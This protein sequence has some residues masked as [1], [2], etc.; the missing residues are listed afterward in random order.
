MRIVECLH[1]GVKNRVASASFSKI[2]VCGKCGAP[3]PE[4]A[5]A[6]GL[7]TL[8]KYRYWVIL[9]AIVGGAFLT[10]ELQESRRSPAARATPATTSAGLTAAQPK[11]QVP[12]PWE[13]VPTA[14][15][16]HQGVLARFTSEEA[17]AP[18][19]IVTPQGEDNYYVK[20]VNAYTGAPALTLFIYGGQ[21]F[22]TEV[23]LGVYVIRYATG[24]TWLGEERLFG[25]KTSYSQADKTFNFAIEGNQVSGYTVELIR[26]QAGNLRTKSI[27]AQQF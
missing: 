18:L 4:H 3:L 22:D 19:R 26:Q 23:P 13:D 5:A 7:R 15:A 16:V 9:L 11:A 8:V 17:I 12:T 27:S 10:N 1:C 24:K 14:V 25:P 6:Q 20:V 21:S 2:P